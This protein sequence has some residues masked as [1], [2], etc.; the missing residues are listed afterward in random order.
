MILLCLFPLQI[1]TMAPECFDCVLNFSHCPLRC[2]FSFLCFAVRQF[3]INDKSLST[4]MEKIVVFK[5]YKDI[6]TAFPCIQLNCCN[7]CLFH[8]FLL[9]LGLVFSFHCNY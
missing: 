8:Y 1:P 9:F 5:F 6:A 7:D 2:D 3:Q 4:G